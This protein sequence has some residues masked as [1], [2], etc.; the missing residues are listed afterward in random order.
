MYCTSQKSLGVTGPKLTLPPSQ[1]FLYTM[2]NYYPSEINVAKILSGK[3]SK[4]DKG[5]VA[6]TLSYM[7]ER[8]TVEFP[9]LKLPYGI[10]GF[11]QDDSPPKFDANFSLGGAEGNKKTQEVLDFVNAFDE[12]M[13]DLGVEHVGK[14]GFHAFK[15]GAKLNLSPKTDAEREAVREKLKEF[16]M[17]MLKVSID[18]KT[19]LPKDYPPTI[20]AGI[21]KKKGADA[22]SL[23]VD[24]FQPEFYNGTERDKD[25]NVSQFADVSI[26]DIAPKA[27]VGVPVEQSTGIWGS[28]VGWGG[29][30]TLLQFRV[31]SRTT[32]KKG[33][34]FRGDAP[35][36]RASETVAASEDEGDVVAAMMPGA[37][38]PKPKPKPKAA[39]TAPVKVV[40]EEEDE[41]EEPKAV[42]AVVVAVAQADSDSSDGEEPPP[43]SVPAKA[44]VKAV[45]AAADGSDSDDSRVDAAPVVPAKAPRKPPGKR[46]A[47]KA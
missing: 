32:T 2:T 30:W 10:K 17:P 14:W 35:D 27:T 26:E 46:A 45:A 43:K 19:N 21:R 28:S 9:P 15:W 23:N 18:K 38:K 16:Y 42:A 44:L 22:R 13:L 7:D 34:M 39:V 12:R 31:D 37:A 6:I 24:T 4:T 40:E 5:T 11:T 36:V 29:S 8:L 33:P 25:G 41:V 3:A 1:L 20:K 47:T